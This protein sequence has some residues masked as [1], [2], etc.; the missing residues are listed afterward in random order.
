MSDHR[1][2]SLRRRDFLVVTAGGLG[3]LALGGVREAL[4]RARQ[5]GKPLLT[6]TSLNRFILEARANPKIYQ[7]YAGMAEKDLY[8]FLSKNFTLTEAQSYSIRHLT[9]ENT[10]TLTKAIDASAKLVAGSG[11]REEP[12]P[13]DWS[14]MMFTFSGKATSKGTAKITYSSTSSNTPGGGHT[15]THTISAEVSY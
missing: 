4:A 9:K 13:A 14:P 7:Q 12:L 15:S 8:A 3:C 10:A 11:Q 5:T 2:G 6:D 1:E